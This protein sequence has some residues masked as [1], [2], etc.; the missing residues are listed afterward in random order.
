MIQKR[1]KPLFYKP[2]LGYLFVI[3]SLRPYKDT[4]TGEWVDKMVSWAPNTAI[5]Y[6]DNP[7]EIKKKITRAVTGGKNPLSLQKRRWKS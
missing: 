4:R 6:S 2:Y 7:D 5:F 3:K 1:F